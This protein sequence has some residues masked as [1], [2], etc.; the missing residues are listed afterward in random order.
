MS[1]GSLFRRVFVWTALLLG[2]VTLLGTQPAAAKATVILVTSTGHE[3]APFVNDGDCTLGEALAA[4][5]ADQRID[6][7]T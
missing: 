6:G 1:Q 5:A 2:L 3:V 7:C 4:A